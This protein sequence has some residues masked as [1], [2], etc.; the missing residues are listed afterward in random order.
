VFPYFLVWDSQQV[1]GILGARQ[2]LAD[3]HIKVNIRHIMADEEV[4]KKRKKKKTEEV[5][6]N[7][8]S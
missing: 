3:T 4:V 6:F 8:T 2:Q 7:G 5:V 1:A